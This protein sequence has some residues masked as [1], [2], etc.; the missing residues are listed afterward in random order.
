M[1]DGAQNSRVHHASVRGGVQQSRISIDSELKFHS[2]IS[3][4]SYSI[5]SYLIA[6]AKVEMCRQLF[7]GRNIEFPTK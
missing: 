7:L 3:A 5:G 2:L 4:T 6:E 1:V